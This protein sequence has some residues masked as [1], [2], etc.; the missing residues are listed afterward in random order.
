MSEN[1]EK[2]RKEG[3]RIM[4]VHYDNTGLQ[5]E[6]WLYDGTLYEIET[7]GKTEKVEYGAIEDIKDAIQCAEDCDDVYVT[8]G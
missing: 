5:R 2:I 6:Y 4:T 3:K 1:I 7:K 8:L